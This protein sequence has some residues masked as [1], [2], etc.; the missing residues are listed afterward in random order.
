[1][2]PRL[3]RNWTSLDVLDL[4][5]PMELQI[6]ADDDPKAGAPE[7]DRPDANSDSEI[8]RRSVNRQFAHA[9]RFEVLGNLQSCTDAP[10]CAAGRTADAPVKL[11]VGRAG[12]RSSPARCQSERGY[13]RERGSMHR[14]DARQAAP[15]TARAVQRLHRPTGGQNTAH[16]PRPHQRPPDQP[17]RASYDRGWCG[18]DARRCSRVPALGQRTTRS[19]KPGPGRSRAISKRDRIPLDRHA[20]ATRAA[21][22]RIRNSKKPSLL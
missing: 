21:F 6:G 19:R 8:V 22:Q 17:Q 12:D 4:A 2:R 20:S 3:E 5:S 7:R 10:R 9:H 1:M 16:R 14:P 15:R 13:A 18:F 11:S